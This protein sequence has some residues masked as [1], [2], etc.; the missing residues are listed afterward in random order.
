MAT[1]HT[2]EKDIRPRRDYPV[3]R[4]LL[5]PADGLIPIITG[6]FTAIKLLYFLAKAKPQPSQIKKNRKKTRDAEEKL[7]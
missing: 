2:E 5:L 7:L 1:G 4:T 6:P 3:P